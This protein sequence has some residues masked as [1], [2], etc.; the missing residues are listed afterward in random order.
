MRG[1]RALG[2]ALV[3]GIGVHACDPSPR[4]APAT[5][6]QED[7]LAPEWT[8]AGNGAAAA[9]VRA[10]ARAH[11]VPVWVPE[12]IG[13]RGGYAA[14]NDGVARVALAARPPNAD[15]A[16]G[17]S[18]SAFARCPLVVVV[19][20]TNPVPRLGTPDLVA[21]VAGDVDTWPDGT[22]VV[23]LL[24]EPGDTGEATVVEATPEL[25]PALRSARASARWPVARSDDDTAA[26]VAQIPGAIAFV[27]PPLL[28]SGHH[29]V[30]VDGLRPGDSAWPWWRTFIVAWRSG[31][32]DAAEFAARLSSETPAFVAHLASLGCRV[33][34]ATP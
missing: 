10:W 14:L 5:C 21:L 12:S 33:A 9:L 27:D 8:V 15:E 32:A 30:P 34:Q 13:S 31:D 16:H 11:D 23:P 24:R 28:H 4:R 26:L 7:D 22:P 6:S 18:W 1:L 20:A 17:L 2:L 29:V 25:G 19:A 3:A